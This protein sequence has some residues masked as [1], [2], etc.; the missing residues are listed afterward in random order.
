M[1]RILMAGAAAAT[2]GCAG[3]GI[4]Q[5]V[6]SISA[7]DKATGAQAH[8]Q[9]LE[10]FGG[11]YGGKQA[12]YVSTVG[13]KVAMQSGLGNSQS[14]FTITLLNSPVNN[15]FAIPG[16][17]VYVTRQ[18][19]GLMND[20]AELAF[21]LG[22]EIGH[23]AARHS[24][25]REK[26]ATRNTILGTLGQILVGVVAGNSGLGQL[27][28]Q[29]IGTGSQLLTLKFSR[30][31]EY[32]AD[33]LGIR[34][35]AKA[36]YDPTASSTMLALL[37]AQ[38]ALEARLRGQDANATP[39]WASTHPNGPDRVTRARA[40]A[41]QI[42]VRPGSGIRNRES[43]LNALDGAIY[44]DDPRQGIVEG[45]SF[46]H[47]VLKIAFTA[48]Q[49]YALANGTRAVSITGTGG[50]AQFSGGPTPSGGLPAYIDTVFRSLSDSQIPYGD[51]RTTTVNGIPV[52]Y[53]GA[54]VTSSNRQ[55]DVTVFAYGTGGAGAYHFVTITPAGSGLGAFDS[56]VGS[57]TRLSDAQAAQIKPRRIDVVTVKPGD[58]L[59]SLA[60]RM[61]YGD[62]R[63]ER[64]LTLNGLTSG[65]AL[66]PGQKVKLVVYG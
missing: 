38:T 3:Y 19:M 31:Q 36:G 51:V 8:P 1:R 24:A 26:A 54:R 17:Y 66:R 59:N 20:E 27:L 48:P 49:G 34:Y 53:A 37:N 30:A 15:A 33:D 42:G 57:F 23:V 6:E 43:F 64:F 46:K 44:D 45:R 62:Y 39:E 47:P 40:R 2:I 61:A 63:V 55:I 32:E 21:V 52:A 10:E 29:G 28:Q 9:L 50:Q 65:S 25:K 11:A 14:D 56:M 16:G 22:H 58:T 13:K 5:T 18:L 7:K 12:A 60:G 41:Q 4:A 35:L